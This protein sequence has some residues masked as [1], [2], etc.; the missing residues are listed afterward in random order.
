MFHQMQKYHKLINFWLD[1]PTA[2]VT[3]S[4]FDSHDW[5]PVLYCALYKCVCVISK[6]AKVL[7]CA[8]H[9]SAGVGDFPVVFGFGQGNGFQKLGVYFLCQSSL[10]NCGLY[11][12]VSSTALPKT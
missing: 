5:R 12:Y 4:S 7:L 8:V 6:L 3:R 1:I 2:Q 10:C 9:L 11:A